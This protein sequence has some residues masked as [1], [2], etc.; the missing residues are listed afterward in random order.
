MRLSECLALFEVLPE[1]AASLQFGHHHPQYSVHA[2]RHDGA[3][4]H[5]AVAHLGSIPVFHLIADVLDAPLDDETS[6]RSDHVLVGLLDGEI[7]A[8][9]ILRHQEPGCDAADLLSD[10]LRNRP[11]DRIAG[12]I[13][14]ERLRQVFE[15]E[16]GRDQ[17]LQGLIV[18]L[19]LLRRLSH[20][21]QKPRQDF[22]VVLSTAI[23]GKTS[24]DVRVDSAAL[25]LGRS[26]RKQAVGG[27]SGKL[28]ARIGLTCAKDQRMSLRGTSNI[29]R[30]A[31][32]EVLAL[33]IEYVNPI[34]PQ[35]L[36]GRLV[37]RKGIVGP[38]VPQPPHDRGEFRR[39]V[40]AF[41]PRHVI[42]PAEVQAVLGVGGGDEVPCGTT[43]TDVIQRG[44]F[45]R[46]EERLLVGCRRSGDQPD[47]I[48]HRGDDREQRHRFEHRRTIGWRSGCKKLRLVHPPDAISVGEKDKVQFGGLHHL[49]HLD[50]ILKI[51]DRHGPGFRVPPTRKMRT[52]G[53][54]VRAENHARSPQFTSAPAQPRLPESLGRTGCRRRRPGL[55]RKYCRHPHTSVP[56]LA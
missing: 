2:V 27:R 4:E 20:I 56:S 23:P 39:P 30:A 13:H 1:D 37:L 29:E 12:Q 15:T 53:S 54:D 42:R 28:L 19:G 25:F 40:V 32:G 18:V 47:V 45:P 8:M 38:A 9:R 5:E 31:D 14:L 6:H 21:D 51:H 44:E 49:R 46:D 33:V 36:S 41:V 48:R 17:R 55:G 7:V 26:R 24:L 35:E 34:R 50:R 43:A 10:E 22:Q 11:V 52:Q 16:V 3:A